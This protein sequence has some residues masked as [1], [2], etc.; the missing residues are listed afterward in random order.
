MLQHIS[1]QG[2]TDKL[3]LYFSVLAQTSSW[4]HYA[5]WV[6]WQ[7]AQMMIVWLLYK[8][9]SESKFLSYVWQLN[10]WALI[11]VPLYTFNPVFTRIYRTVIVFNAIAV[12][13]S[14][15]APKKNQVVVASLVLTTAQFTMSIVSFLVMDYITSSSLGFNELVAPIFTNNIFLK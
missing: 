10:I 13:N 6:V 11:F 8:R 9:N 4:T 14:I 5:F 12:G 2:M 15:R 1:I 3:E 7:V